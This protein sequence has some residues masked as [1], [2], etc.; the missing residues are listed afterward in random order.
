MINMFITN[1]MYLSLYVSPHF[2]TG[3]KGSSFPGLVPLDERVDPD[4]VV[5]ANLVILVQ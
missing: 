2:I 4:S 5:T 3:R 1:D